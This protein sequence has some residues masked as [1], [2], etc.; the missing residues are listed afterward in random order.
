MMHWEY[1]K[2]KIKEFSR[3]YSINKKRE[4]TAVRISLESKLKSLTE[5]LNNNSSS[6]LF[7]EYEECKNRLES[8]YQNA[9]NGL[10]IR[11]KVDWYEKGEKSNKYFYNLEKRNK[12]KTH[13]KSLS[14]ENKNTVTHDQK[15]IMT[16]L[17]SFYSTLYSRKS[18]MSE[19]QCMDYLAEINTPVLSSEVKDLCDNHITLNEIFTALNAM[20]S[21]KTPGNDGLTNKFYLAFFDILGSRLLKCLNYAFSAGELPTSQR[22]AVIT[23]IEKRG[24]DKRSIK[25]WRPISLLNV[26]AKIISKVLAH[27]VKKI[28][29]SLISSDQTAYVPGRYIGESVRLTSNLIDFTDTH[30]IP[31]Y[32]LTIDIEKAFDS[33]DHTFLCSTVK[34]LDLATISFI[35]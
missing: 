3:E 28:I 19:K 13:V 27:R 11:S 26:D 31:G 22:Q 35:G 4:H 6:E 17:K 23:L 16:K 24:R 1:L 15:L 10:I 20:S 33:V 32:L 21:N 18:S 8:L 25:N 30:S 29:S 2:Y 7:R 34:N 12:T 9:T 5:S 14:D